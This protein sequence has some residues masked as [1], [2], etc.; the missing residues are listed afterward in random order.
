MDPA[1]DLGATLQQIGDE[2][3]HGASLKAGR[4]DSTVK[5]FCR[6]ENA[7]EPRVQLQ[8]KSRWF[9]ESC[10][11]STEHCTGMGRPFFLEET[12]SLLRSQLE[13]DKADHVREVQRQAASAAEALAA[14]SALD[15]GELYN[16][17]GRIPMEG[18][19]PGGGCVA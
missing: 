14:A 7:E 19:G 3:G 5:N 1:A 8:S 2:E 9:L 17:P 4:Q 10:C 15:I 16:V 12:F 6:L 18:G 13:I 11:L